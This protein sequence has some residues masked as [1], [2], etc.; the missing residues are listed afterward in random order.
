M[1]TFSLAENEIGYG[2]EPALFVCQIRRV[3]CI[4]SFGLATNEVSEQPKETP[5]FYPA[6]FTWT[7]Y[8]LKSH[9][10]P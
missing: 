6:P 10:R 7:S 8:L 2:V 4:S 1:G 3:F 5:R 9:S